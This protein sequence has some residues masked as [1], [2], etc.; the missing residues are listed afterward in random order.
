MTSSSKNSYS[1]SR[2]SASIPLVGFSELNDKTIKGLTC[3]LKSC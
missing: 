3:L 1:D 2:E